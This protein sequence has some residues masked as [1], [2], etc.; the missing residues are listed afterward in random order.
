MYPRTQFQYSY[1]MPGN[2][3]FLLI[4][5]DVFKTFRT[6]A[7]AAMSAKL[8]IVYVLASVTVDAVF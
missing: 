1:E 7:I 8:A 3:L 6:V 5:I 4:N 2:P